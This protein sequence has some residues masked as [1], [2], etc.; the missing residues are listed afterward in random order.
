[1]P[2]LPTVKPTAPKAPPTTGG[3][4]SAT[5]KPKE[6]P[7]TTWKD[8]FKDVLSNLSLDNAKQKIS[9]KASEKLS[10]GKF[11]DNSKILA[12][13]LIS[14][15]LKQENTDNLT[16]K[17]PSPK[18]L[19]GILKLMVDIESQRKLNTIN[20]LRTTKFE[21]R[22]LQRRHKE[23][24]KALTIKFEPRKKPVTKIGRAHV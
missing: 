1:M 13:K 19:K 8:R 10:A 21:E 7:R 20:D 6:A 2:K 17:S 11:K 16:K 3:K 12:S 9:D 18:I 5:V 23:I 24:I 15:F 22:E 14:L 4:P